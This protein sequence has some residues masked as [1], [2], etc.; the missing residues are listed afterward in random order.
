MPNARDREFGTS[1]A[2]LLGTWEYERM[3]PAGESGRVIPAVENSFGDMSKLL[4]GEAC[5]WPSANGT[6]VRLDNQR[7]AAELP[8]RLIDEFKDVR[9]TALFYFVGHGQLSADDD[10]LLTVSGS[11]SD[12]VYR[13]ATS[14]AFGSVVEAMRNCRAETRIIILDCCNSGNAADDPALRRGVPDEFYLMMGSATFTPA[15][16]E[17]GT[18]VERPQTYFTKA[19][20]EVIADG[21]RGAG[22]YLTLDEVFTAAHDRL[23]ETSNLPR[24]TRRMGMSA[25]D[26]LIARN[27][28][29]TPANGARLHRVERRAEIEQWLG[30]IAGVGRTFDSRMS[31][32]VSLVDEAVASETARNAL[33]QLASDSS[34]PLLIRL[35]CV[36][37]I[38]RY[39][40]GEA[41]IAALAPLVGGER[42]RVAWPAM[43]QF[44]AETHKSE[45]GSW[46]DDWQIA[47]ASADPVRLWGVLMAVLMSKAGFD[48]EQRLTAVRELAA[49]GCGEHARWIA[50]GMLCDRRVGG[51]TRRRIAAAAG[52]RGWVFGY[53][54]GNR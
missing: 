41:A 9:G 15:W 2:V 25:R 51:A 49:A 50:E 36:P 32:L 1:K 39:I 4:L 48:V 17:T 14:L 30:A 29:F 21:I 19:L 24:P 42:A 37:E 27:R 28:A 34:V 23:K 40:S 26:Y 13:R 43:A 3:H 38:G 8:I 47:E 11:D 44:I 10:L 7:S 16:Y 46:A 22:E 52:L 6:V 20:V 5:G 53:R 31:A 12:Y 35:R 54:L 45:I 33:E 18:D